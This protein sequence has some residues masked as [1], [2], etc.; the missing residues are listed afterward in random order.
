MIYVRELLAG[1][2]SPFVV[3]SRPRF[4]R[5]LQKFAH[6][7]LYTQL[8]VNNHSPSSEAATPASGTQ[9][10]R[11]RCPRRVSAQVLSD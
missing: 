7:E 8:Y 2:L 6:T 4:A 3:G 11:G 1:L 10:L 9:L 5:Q